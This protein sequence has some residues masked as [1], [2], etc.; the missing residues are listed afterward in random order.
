MNASLNPANKNARR[1]NN[2]FTL[3]KEFIYNIIKKFTSKLIIF[4]L[5]LQSQYKVFYIYLFYKMRVL[6]FLLLASALSLNV[7]A[8]KVTADKTEGCA[9]VT[10]SFE[11]PSSSTTFFWDMGDGSISDKEKPSN[12]YINPGK[13]TVKFRES[14]N[15]PVLGSIDIKVYEK[16]KPAYVA[17]PAFG[18]PLVDIKFKNATVMDPAIKVSEYYWTFGD[19]QGAYGDSVFHAF[20]QPGNYKIALNFKTNFESCVNNDITDNQLTIYDRPQAAFTTDPGSTFT[21]ENN[22]KVTYTNVS[23]GEKTKDLVYSWDFANGNK[24][25]NKDPLPQN[26]TKGQYFSKL[27]IFF[28]DA[29]ACSSE[30]SKAIS[31]GKP[32][33]HIS[34]NKDSVC[35]I[36]ETMFR[37]TSIGRLT[38]EI[39]GGDYMRWDYR[40]SIGVNFQNGGWHKVKLT[41]FSDD[42]LCFDTASVRVYVRKLDA[43]I[44]SIPDFSCSNPAVVTYKVISKEKKLTYDWSFSDQAM[45]STTETVTKIYKSLSDSLY[46]GLNKM[47]VKNVSVKVTSLVTGCRAEDETTDTI[48]IPNARFVPNITKGCGPL[49]VVFSDSSKTFVKN[50]IVSWKWLF[51]DDNNSSVVKTDSNDVSFTYNNPGV[52]YP[53]L[54][55][56]T[57]KGCIDTSYA[58]R[59]EVGEEVASRLDFTATPN[60][61]CPGEAVN[62]S[63]QNP[64]TFINAYHFQTEDNRSFHCSDLK[65]VSWSYNNV[66]GPQDV[67]LNV[68][69]NGC[70]STLKK[71]NVVTVKGAIP[72]I[73][74]LALCND[75]L[76]YTFT[77]KTLGP[78]DLA[79]KFGDGDTSISVIQEHKFK[80]SGDYQ[81]QLT[82]KPKDGSKCAAITETITVTPRVVEA[83]ISYEKAGDSLFCISSPHILRASKSKDVY[84]SCHRGYT[85]QFP[86]MKEMR[87]R[88]TEDSV[89]S[90]F[91]SEAGEH[92]VRLI[93][94]DINGCKDTTTARIKI[95]D[96]KVDAKPN[97][98][99]I[100]LPN[101]VSIADLSIADTTI[102]SWK[103]NFL[104]DTIIDYTTFRD[105]LSRYFK[106][107]IAT[108]SIGYSLT[109]TDTLGCKETFTDYINL[110]APV[111][112][113]QLK[114]KICV[115]DTVEI[116]ALD[117]TAGGSS[118]E[119]L[120][121]MGF[122][123]DITGISHKVVYE[124]SGS[125]P[126]SLKYTE[127]GSGCSGN[128]IEYISVQSYPKAKFSSLTIDTLAVICADI[129]PVLRDSSKA[130]DNYSPILW[131]YWEADNQPSWD[132]SKNPPLPA[133]SFPRGD[134][135]M[136][137][138]VVTENG[139]SDTATRYF[140]AE[141]AE[142]NF[143]MSK[144]RI[145]LDDVITF[146]LVDTIDVKKWEW[147]FEGD[148]ISM[149]DHVTH[150]F[151]THPENNISKAKLKL[152]SWKGGCFRAFE[153]DVF[154]HPVIARFERESEPSDTSI[155]FNDGPFHL[156][157]T[158][159]NNDKFKW[160][161]GDGTSEDS[162]TSEPAHKYQTPGKYDVTLTIKNNSL[163]CVDTLKKVAL[164]YPNP[165][166]TASSDT[167][168]AG[169]TEIANIIHLNVDHPVAS[170]KYHWSPSDGV[171]NVDSDSTTAIP[172]MTTL[173]KVVET[174]TATGCQDFAEVTGLVIQK[175]GLQDWDTTIVIGDYATLPV[176]GDPVYKF[177]W[178]P[179]KYLSCL[180]CFYPKAQPLEDITYNLIVTDVYSCFTDPYKFEITVKPE[181][182][183]KLP[184]AFT[185]NGDTKNDKVYVK[186]WGIKKLVEY[187]VFNRWGQ[188]IFSTDDINEGW[189]GTFK[190]Q[191]Q[192]SDVYVYK[193]KVITW[194]EEEKYVEGY[195][196]LLY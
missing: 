34:T 62:F 19:A 165:D 57:S 54:V 152:T 50:P 39:T 162:V 104:N 67:Y 85:W 147:N 110:Y 163:G 155:C 196:N 168:C 161:F 159:I 183:V 2:F 109:L 119:F 3:L 103:W 184:S 122:G 43:K 36:S 48:Y 74:Y 61:V 5:T 174:D 193:V 124:N 120:W 185:P 80:T 79:W 187:K 131:K 178:T 186:G 53:R 81:V 143:V 154:V 60:E 40:D 108:E 175:I 66:V 44:Q 16:P 99:R 13:Y 31:V 134:H 84:A 151:T 106:K 172:A 148:T 192:N 180:D 105:S 130:A 179:E 47:E 127:K 1:R 101:A 49:T 102:V 139:C 21:C 150:K 125:F 126:V 51:G 195:I 76:K 142:G 38:W 176:Y 8:Q 20:S 121:N 71:S 169:A 42:G 156:K 149:V 137:L 37:T 95:Y 55:V 86:T 141:N 83:A 90:F 114:S 111:S 112:T 63:V 9:P 29:P 166:V 135:Y 182:F 94:E 77:S 160:N 145:C 64:L 157:N 75:P 123:P 191:Q 56:T 87:P 17:E 25:S 89:T 194:K 73:D 4:L 117:Y 65:D 14:K 164:V 33:A 128:I 133:W 167:M 171:A 10:V 6:F 18:C 146:S 46:Y 82:A 23:V 115:G 72:Q 30:V 189:D 170:S 129:S 58:V 153:Q 173:Y 132:N 116:K 138:K 26:Y 24:T 91:F 92:S 181:T 69:Y 11:A 140:R 70:I 52:Y 27:K 118:L 136:K 12:Q 188:E 144:N 107:G 7:L 35:N 45:N 88:T 22:L 41:V 158:S 32:V 113:I 190:G 78:A 97:K 96:M 28:K 93:V 98:E 177:S 68:D 15:G 100:C 59:I